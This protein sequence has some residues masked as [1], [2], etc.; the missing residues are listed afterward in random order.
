MLSNWPVA[1]NAQHDPQFP[2]FLTGVTRSKVL[3]SKL[4]GDKNS[5]SEL[6][7]GLEESGISNS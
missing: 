4:V 3:Q 7:S 6:K 5:W 1:A 2:W